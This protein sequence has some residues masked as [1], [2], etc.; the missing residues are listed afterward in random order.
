MERASCPKLYMRAGTAR[1]APAGDTCAFVPGLDLQPPPRDPIRLVVW[2]L[3]FHPSDIWLSSIS[4]ISHSGPPS[5]DHC[6]SALTT[7][8]HPILQRPRLHQQNNIANMDGLTMIDRSRHSFGMY[9]EPTRRDA[10]M[11]HASYSSTSHSTRYPS[12]HSPPYNSGESGKP[13]LP[14]LRSVSIL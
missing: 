11:H 4:L 6:T 3:C 10:P 9:H 13:S 8:N 12:S 1:P 7:S 14:S 2:K 5:L